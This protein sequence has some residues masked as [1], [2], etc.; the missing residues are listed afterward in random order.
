LIRPAPG[1]ECNPATARYPAPT[2]VLGEHEKALD[3]LEPLLEMLSYLFPGWLATDP[4]FA[5]LNGN[6]RYERL[7]KKTE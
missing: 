2:F 4:N 1:R 5:P 6:A 3:R 7:L